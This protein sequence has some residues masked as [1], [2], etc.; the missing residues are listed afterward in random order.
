MRISFVILA[1]S[2]AGLAAPARAD[3]EL[4]GQPKPPDAQTPASAPGKTLVISQPLPP[5]SH[6]R[7]AYPVAKGFGKAVPLEFAVRQI[8]PSEIKV[9][10]GPTE[11]R[12]MQIDWTG[13]RAWIAVL[14]DAV[15]A[16]GL[17]VVLKKGVV[18]IRK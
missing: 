3:F 9:A 15:N 13:G 1:L 14:R 17:H 11:D 12:H 2:C 10:F 18:T 6:P 5:P 4:V 16:Q 8:V 7:P